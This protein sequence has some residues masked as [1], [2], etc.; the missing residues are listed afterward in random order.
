MPLVPYLLRPL[1]VQ[2]ELL[3]TCD[4]FKHDK[5]RQFKVHVPVP[6]RLEQVLVQFAL[7][8]LVSLFLTWG[9]LVISISGIVF[10]GCSWAAIWVRI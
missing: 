8:H 6:H 3:G 4:R 7:R 9:R 5:A 1:R 10:R 2:V